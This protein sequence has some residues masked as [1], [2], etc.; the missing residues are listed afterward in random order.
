MKNLLLAIL[1]LMSAVL[2]TR[3]K[4]QGTIYYY[5]PE[6]NVY[7]NTHSH[8]YAYEDNGNWSYQTTLPSYLK[9]NKRSHITVYSNN[10]DVW[11]N[12]QIHKEI[13]REWFDK[14]KKK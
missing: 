9:I 5:Y 11:K 3:V 12:N 2:S 13:Y 8:Q 14:Q 1:I 6:V 4:A 10:M 7:Y